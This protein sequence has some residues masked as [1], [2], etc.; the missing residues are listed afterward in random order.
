MN[1]GLSESSG[2]GPSE[3][4][5]F[6]SG[7]TEHRWIMKDVPQL[8]KESFTST[9]DNYL[10]R[11]EFQLSG[12]GEPLQPKNIMGSWPSLSQ[13]LMEN[14]YFGLSLKSGNGFLS[15]VVRPLIVSAKDDEEKAR[16]IYAYV[17]DNITCTDHSSV[18]MDK[19][20]KDVLKTRK[21]T[22][23]EVNLLLTAMLKYAGLKA[24]PAILSTS[25]NGFTYTLYP[26]LRRF[27]YVISRVTT[28]KGTLMLDASHPRLGFGKLTPN[29]YNGQVRV[30]D[31]EATAMH[32]SPDS[33]VEKKMTSLFV[34][35]TEQGKWIAKARHNTGYYESYNIR[36]KIK[37]K[38]QESFF[39][40]LQTSIGSEIK[41]VEPRI[42]SLDN[43]DLPLVL[44][45]EFALNKDEED[46][47]YINPMF[48]EGYKENPF[49][50]AERLYP[51]EMPFAM[52]ETY[53][54]TMQVPDGYVLDELPKQIAVKLNEEGD[55]YFEYMLSKSENTISLRSRIK[56]KKTIF[57][58]EEYDYLREFFKL[59][60]TKHNEQIVFKKKANP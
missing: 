29:C 19:S 57:N 16:N 49:K 46:L 58:P 44:N 25:E 40:D 15:D 14:E 52:D 11:I 26:L 60:V 12:Y 28:N 8:K 32:L 21:G 38:G 54:L 53:L 22:V 56:I 5:T 31:T 1:F 9:L 59:V 50:S 37:D 24:E 2:T 45:F 35:N 3:R 42:D 4:I 39:K 18:Y 36:E 34:A 30:I 13:S 47:L 43:Y 20:L 33:L 7:V 6:S 48:G 55:G 27:N 17:R 51:V 23:S 10:S 41:I